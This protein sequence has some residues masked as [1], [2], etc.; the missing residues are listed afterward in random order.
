MTQYMITI[1][2]P[3]GPPPP[4]EFLEAVGQK[5]HALNQDIKA[6]GAWVLTGFRATTRIGSACARFATSSEM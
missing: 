4:R 2:Q 5:L 6:A 3:D 1:Y